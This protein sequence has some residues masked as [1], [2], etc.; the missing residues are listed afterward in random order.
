V[1][2]HGVDVRCLVR[3]KWTYRNTTGRP[4]IPYKVRELIEQLAR[5]NPRWGYR[6]AQ[7]E[8]AGLG[9]LIWRGSDPRILA[10]TGL[11]AAPRR[12][13]PPWRQFLATL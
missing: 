3:N 12:A 1:L 13:P 11:R 9:H 10:A 4:P 5:Q 6:R 8:L 7:G 2:R